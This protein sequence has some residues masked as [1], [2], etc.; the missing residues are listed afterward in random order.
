MLKKRGGR[1]TTVMSQSGWGGIEL[2]CK[3]GWDWLA[4][5]VQAAHLPKPAGSRAYGTDAGEGWVCGGSPREPLQM[6]SF[7]QWDRKLHCTW[8]CTWARNS[9]IFRGKRGRCKRGT[10]ERRRVSALDKHGVTAG[11][12]K[13]LVMNKSRSVSLVVTVVFSNVHIQLPRCRHEQTEWHKLK[14]QGCGGHMQS[15]QKTALSVEF[16]L[17]KEGRSNIQRNWQKKSLSVNG[18]SVPMRLKD[19]WDQVEDGVSR[20]IGGGG[21]N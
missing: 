1:I 17:N 18:S 2:M 19:C 14:W 16:I 9:G 4:V 5:G 15:S 12:L 21:Q 8:Q 7:S 13:F 10:L 6:A 3:E 20:K 11:S